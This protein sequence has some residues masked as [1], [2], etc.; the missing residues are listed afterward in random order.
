MVM[1][2]I[3]EIPSRLLYVLIVFFELL[4]NIQIYRNR[5]MTDFDTYRHRNALG[6]VS[7]PWMSTNVFDFETS[8]RVCCE[9]TME[10]LS[11]HRGD[12]L[13]NRKISCHYLL[14]E[15]CRVRVFKG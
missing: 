3:L 4:Q 6:G 1:S 7:E 5:V 2:V 12:K 11:S 8:L 9:D 15:S 13:R 14:I 10:H